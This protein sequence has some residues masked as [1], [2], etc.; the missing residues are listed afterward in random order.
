VLTVD[1]RNQFDG[2]GT[3]VREHGPVRVSELP[4]SLE[5]TIRRD[6]QFAVAAAFGRLTQETV[7][8]EALGP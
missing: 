3:Y 7:S 6:G 8:K 5:Y 2:Q 4:D 1:A